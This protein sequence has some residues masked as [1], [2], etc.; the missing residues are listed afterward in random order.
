MIFRFK[1][2][3]KS[4]L[5]IGWLN[6]NENRLYELWKIPLNLLE[7]LIRISLESGEEHT[8]KIRKVTDN[9]NDF[10][11]E[12][13][14]KIHARALQISNEIL[15]LLKSGYAD[16]ANARWRSLHELAV[17][18]F[19]LLHNNNDVAKRYLEH[20][21]I[22]TFK[23]AKDY[24]AYYKKLGYSPI[25]IKKYNKIKKEK[26]EICKKYNDE[27]QID[28]GWI[29]S[30]LLKNRNFRAL[31]KLVK[32]DKLRPFYNFSSN[33]VHGGAKGF[34]RLGLMK[35]SQDKML[36]AGA[37]NYGLADPLQNTAISLLHVNICLLNLKPDF[38]TIMLIQQVV[39]KLRIN[40]GLLH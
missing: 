27:F 38:E 33:S 12:A 4:K 3:L 21:I 7:C 34:Y 23:E 30:S 35:S 39:P 17:I 22:K 36:L 15:I 18:S 19:F 37:T 11:H 6:S 10:K 31:E 14:I 8:N 40:S 25:E 32:L 9:T 24:R 5:F 26:E 2:F 1:C 29:P 28:Y 13:L 20:A 16:G